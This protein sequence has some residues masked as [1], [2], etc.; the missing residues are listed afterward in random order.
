MESKVC[1]Q[2]GRQGQAPIVSLER[3]APSKWQGR[4][5]VCSRAAELQYLQLNLGNSFGNEEML[6]GGQVML[7]SQVRDFFDSHVG[8]HASLRMRFRRCPA[9]SGPYGKAARM[10][11]SRPG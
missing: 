4:V 8:W 2:Q 9:F 10:A 11:A 1:M 7:P 3:E 6:W 5:C